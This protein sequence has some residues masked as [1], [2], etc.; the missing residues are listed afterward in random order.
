MGED[1][2]QHHET[3]LNIRVALNAAVLGVVPF[4]RPIDRLRGQ[5]VD[6][7]TLTALDHMKM[8]VAIGLLEKSGEERYLRRVPRNGKY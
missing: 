2:V 4:E 3:R 6:V 8:A 7:P 5:M 1:E